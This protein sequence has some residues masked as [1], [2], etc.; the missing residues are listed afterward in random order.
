MAPS[1]K[2]DNQLRIMCTP[3][4]LSPPAKR[5]TTIIQLT[6]AATSSKTLSVKNLLLIRCNVLFTKSLSIL[7]LDDAYK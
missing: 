5:E 7:I 6:F 4:S 3:L 1:L 2:G